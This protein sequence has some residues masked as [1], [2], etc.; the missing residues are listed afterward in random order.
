MSIASLK[1]NPNFHMKV[2]NVDCENLKVNGATLTLTNDALTVTASPNIYYEISCNLSQANAT[3]IA[4]SSQTGTVPRPGI[5]KYLVNVQAVFDAV[6]F[7]K[8]NFQ[9]NSFITLIVFGVASQTTTNVFNGTLNYMPAPEG[10]NLQQYS[11]SWSSIYDIANNLDKI[12]PN[13]T[14]QNATLSPSTTSA[15]TFKVTLTP[16]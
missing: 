7:N 3:M 2:G 11:Y 6:N 8:I 16:L 10:T 15:V 14:I 9:S 13:I 4:P 12:T 5:G 1:N